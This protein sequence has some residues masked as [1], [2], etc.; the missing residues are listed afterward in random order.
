MANNKLKALKILNPILGILFIVQAGSGMFHGMIPWEIF[1]KVHGT[2]GYLFAAGVV[3]HFILNWS[4][5]K[6]NFLK[7]RPK[8]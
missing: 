6:A 1:E 8:R 5:I 7:P 2:T 3:T 4:W